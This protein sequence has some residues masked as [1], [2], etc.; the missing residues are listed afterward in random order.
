MSQAWHAKQLRM[1]L[2]C[3]SI[4]FYHWKT[5]LNYTVKMKLL[6]LCFCWYSFTTGA[7][8]SVTKPFLFSSWWRSRHLCNSYGRNRNRRKRNKMNYFI[9][10]KMS[11]QNAPKRFRISGVPHYPSQTPGLSVL[12]LPPVF[13]WAVFLWALLASASL[14]T[15]TTLLVFQY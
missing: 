13:L 1:R 5:V 7:L 6:Y 9:T 3:L 2:E 11:W 12:W 15:L 14:T 10:W 4:G 8:R